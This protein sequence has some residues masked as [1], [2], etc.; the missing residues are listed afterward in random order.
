M[1]EITFPHHFNN[2]TDNKIVYYK[3]D[4]VKESLKVAK[5]KISRTYDGE[6]T[7]ITKGEI[8]EIEKLFNEINRKVNLDNFR[9]I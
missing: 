9:L 8:D 2:V 7:E 5:D 4:K 6:K 1:S 3:T